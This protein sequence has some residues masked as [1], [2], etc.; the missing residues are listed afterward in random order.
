MYVCIDWLWKMVLCTLYKQIK[1]VL[2][3]KTE[4]NANKQT[5]NWQGYFGLLDVV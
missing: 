3:V 2:T 4:V 5:T 1:P